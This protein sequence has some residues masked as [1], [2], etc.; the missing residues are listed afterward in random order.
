MNKNEVII[1]VI[2]P[3]YNAE[4]YVKS[5]I[6]SI[7]NQTYKYFEIILINDGSTDGSV[8]ICNKIA[9]KE[10][11][12]KLFS[13]TNGGVVAARKK[14]WENAKGNWIVFVDADDKIKENALEILYNTAL[15]NSVEMVK[16]GLI[17]E[18]SNIMFTNKLM[19]KYTREMYFDAIINGDIKAF[20]TS[21]IFKKELFTAETFTINSDIKIGEDVLMCYE[22]GLKLNLGFSIPNLLYVYRDNH[23]SAS[24]SFLR[25]P[26]YYEKF[27]KSIF[28]IL[29]KNQMLFTKY[30]L[31]L[32]CQL[33]EILLGVFFCY[34][35]PYDNHYRKHLLN[36]ISDDNCEK[37]LSRFILR[38][39]FLCYS[40]KMSTRI[41]KQLYVVF[42]KRKNRIVYSE[43][44]Y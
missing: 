28:E 41:L 10:K 12:I 15:E 20:I 8:L 38:Y 29:T 1:S 35:L 31:P 27:Y 14:G 9:Q 24:K 2:V 7:I 43:V 37:T 19:G 26:S 23:Q 40:F 39:N 42:T 16:A 30:K 13:Q 34:D 22:I 3:I 11:R 4:N 32:Q 21:T 36:I 44:I 25:H 17:T 18:P 6:D 33:N 5:C